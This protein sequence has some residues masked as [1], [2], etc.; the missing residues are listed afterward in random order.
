MVATLGS[1]HAD[2]LDF[3]ERFDRAWRARR[4]GPS[5]SWV[6][7]V[8]SGLRI[9]L[10]QAAGEPGQLQVVPPSRWVALQPGAVGVAPQDVGLPLMGRIGRDGA[11]GDTPATR[12]R[13]MVTILGVH[14]AITAHYE[15]AL[16]IASD[17]TVDDLLEEIEEQPY[18]LDP[19]PSWLRRTG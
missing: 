6:E 9:R 8:R 15:R 16:L 4:V 5:P 1:E 12:I 11:T 2:A 17:D 13:N 14:F 18:E 10:G 19:T 3:R 7:D